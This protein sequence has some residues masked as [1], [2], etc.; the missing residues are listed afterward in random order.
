MDIITLDEFIAEIET[1]FT[2]YAATNDIDKNSIKTWVIT[3]LRKFGKNICDQRET[4]IDIKNSKG[5]LPETFKS[6]ILGLKLTDEDKLNKPDNKRLIV[7]R[8]KI[9]NPAY[10]SYAT[11]DYFVNFCESKITT[12][13]VY[14][15]YEHED[16]CFNY[17]WLSLVKGFDK[18][19]VAVDCLNLNPVIR[20]S[21]PHEISITKRAINT[22]FKNGKIYFQYNS[23][24]SDENGEVAIPIISTGSI[25]EYITNAVKIKLAETL[26]IN[27]KN[28]QTLSQWVSL[29]LQ[30]ERQLF[31]E[32]KSEANWSGL[33]KGWDTR[34]YFKNRINQDRYT[35]PK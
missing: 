4:I 20:N 18:D 28:S 17:E 1:T 34:M 10:F 5:L 3:C 26:G 31:I 23:L 12:E 2:N 7:E 24:F 6:M 33:P 27:D 35:L 11:Q 29:W 19:T 8:Q 15:H 32:A 16:R 14:T 13:K 22:N 21:F 25:L 30:K 9:E